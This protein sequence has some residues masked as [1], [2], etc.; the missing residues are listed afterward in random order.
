MAMTPFNDRGQPLGQHH[1]GHQ[2]DQQQ[3]Q[4]DQRDATVWGSACASSVWS[5]ESAGRK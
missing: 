4:A 3:G 1:H 5:P 2:A